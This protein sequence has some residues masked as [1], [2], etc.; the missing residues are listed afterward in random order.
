M[1]PLFQDT[2][3]DHPPQNVNIAVLVGNKLGLGKRRVEF[4]LKPL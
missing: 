1:E 4:G 3:L 2:G